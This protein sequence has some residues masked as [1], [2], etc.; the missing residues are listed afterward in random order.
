MCHAGDREG[1]IAVL[2]YPCNPVLLQEEV[3]RFY[4][5]DA[6]PFWRLTV[7]RCDRNLPASVNGLDGPAL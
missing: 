1:G 3:I 4:G 2:F 6:F 5:P 7:R